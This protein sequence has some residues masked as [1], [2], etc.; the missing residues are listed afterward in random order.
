MNASRLLAVLAGLTIACGIAGYAPHAEAR[1]V[2]VG[3]DVRIGP[4]PPRYVR[5]PP[6]R[7]GYIWAPGYWRWEGHRHVWVDGYWVRARPG[8]RYE[9]AVWVR[10]GPNWHFVPGHWAR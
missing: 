9:P 4:P 2:A 6:P 7:A 1:P 5:V 3:V 8:W 10:R